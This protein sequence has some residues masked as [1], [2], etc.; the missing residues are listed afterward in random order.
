MTIYSTIAEEINKTPGWDVSVEKIAMPVPL[1]LRDSGLQS[2][3]F[4][5][6]SVAYGLSLQQ[7]LEK[8]VRAIDVPDM[9]R[10]V[11]AD[12]TD[13]YVSKDDC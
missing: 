2:E 6:L 8:I 1:E 4:D 7:G 10:D 13:R 5:R 9:V 3:E 12:L 11:K